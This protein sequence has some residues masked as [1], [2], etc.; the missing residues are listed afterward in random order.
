MQPIYT[1]E[2]VTTGEGRAGGHGRTSDGSLEVT[3]S[4][5]K[6]FGGSGGGGTNPEQLVALGYAA[7]FR[8]AVGVVAARE[9]IRAD[10]ASITCRASIGK[11]AAGDYGLAFEIEGEFPDLSQAEAD[12]LVVEAHQVCPYSRA[13]RDGASVKITARG[14]P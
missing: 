6:E 3:F 7:C 8:S 12:L 10:N 11:T 13:F 1:A 9:K 2:A 14:R 5:P 4:T